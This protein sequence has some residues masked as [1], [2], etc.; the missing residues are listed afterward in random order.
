MARL[1]RAHDIVGAGVERIAH[2]LEF[3]RDFVDKG[4]RRH[5]FARRALLDFQAM[6][7]HARNEQSFAPVQAHETLDR[8]GRD[9]LVGMPDMR[10]SIGV[11][12][13]GGDVETRAHAGR[14]MRISRF[15]QMIGG[16]RNPQPSEG[17]GA[18]GDFL[19]ERQH[20]KLAVEV[21]RFC[22]ARRF[23]NPIPE[24]ARSLPAE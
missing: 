18:L 7:V 13:R 15:W 1:G 5:A 17:S 11:G 3:R 6:L 10:R 4:L 9:A 14:P 21:E 23:A 24:A 22:L 2:L 12:D 19:E 20:V 8:I 16:G